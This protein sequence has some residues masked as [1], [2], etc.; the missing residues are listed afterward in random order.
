MSSVIKIPRIIGHRGAKGHS[1]ENTLVSFEKAKKL[2][3]TWVEFDVKESADGILIIM[4]DDE[5]DR[6]SN[7]KGLVAKTPWHEIQ[8]LDAGSWFDKK[9]TNEKIPTLEQTFNLLKKLKMGANIEIKPCPGREKRTAEAVAKFVHKN[10]PKELP[11]ALIS[12]FSMDALDTVHKM[13]P[14]LA[15]GAL[16]EKI[17]KN[18]KKIA[19]SINAISIHTDHETV[20]EN[21]IKKIKNEGYFVLTYTVNDRKRANE[22]FKIGVDS[23]FTDFPWSE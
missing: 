6:T 17:P 22:L 11:P 2:G 15:L 5:L 20:N 23:I 9:F 1:P 19:K 4:H 13:F 12:S 21:L 8:K 16:F 18:W 14:N 10:W 3:A 7:G